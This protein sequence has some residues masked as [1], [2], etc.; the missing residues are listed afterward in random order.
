MSCWMGPCAGRGRE[1]KEEEHRP[2]VHSERR[3]TTS[4]THAHTHTHTL[5]ILMHART[6]ARA[7]ARARTHAP[8]KAEEGVRNG[9]EIEAVRV[10]LACAS[11]GKIDIQGLHSKTVLD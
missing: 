8:G 7:R 6:R 10:E 3:A 11:E 2:A 1:G 9:P 4:K 5:D